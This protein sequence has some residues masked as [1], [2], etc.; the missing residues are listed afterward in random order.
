[1]CLITDHVKLKK[2]CQVLLEENAKLEAQVEA[3]QPP[4]LPFGYPVYKLPWAEL[5]RFLLVLDLQPMVNPEYVADS[6]VTY[7]DKDSWAKIIPFLV[8]P[9][10]LYVEEVADCDDYSKWAAAD[11]SKLFNLNG[12]LQCWGHMPLGYHAWNLVL[13]EG[14]YKLFDANAGFPHAGQLFNPMDNGY[15]PEAWK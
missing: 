15:K 2:A 1:M 3:L 9:A 7:T 4:V 8:Y 6:Y 5:I 14:G 13:I 10:D 12:C 11:S